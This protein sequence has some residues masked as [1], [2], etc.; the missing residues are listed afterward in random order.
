VGDEGEE[1][2]EEGEEGR[3]KVN[4]HTRQRERKIK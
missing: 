1:E 3:A 4:K 2:G